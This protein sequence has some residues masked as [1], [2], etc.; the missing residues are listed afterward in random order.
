[1]AKV[2][3]EATLE[4]DAEIWHDLDPDAILWFINDVLLLGDNAVHNNE[5]VGDTLGRLKITKV[6][7]DA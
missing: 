4:Y 2:T 7:R 5:P 6:V 3:I 1:M